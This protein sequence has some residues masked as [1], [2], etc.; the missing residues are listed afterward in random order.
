MNNPFL[1]QPYLLSLDPAHE[2]SVVWLQLDQSSC[3][4]E[5]GDTEELGRSAVCIQY[6]VTGLK[7][8]AN[9]KQGYMETPE[10]NLPLEVYQ[11]IAV[12]RGLHEGERVFYRCVSGDE[13]TRVYDFHAA[14]AEGEGYRFALMSDL[15]GLPHCD[16]TVSRIGREDCDFILYAGDLNWMS[17]QA[18]KWFALDWP[19]Q[20]EDKKRKA[21]FP[22]M[23]QEGSRLMQYC[24]TFFCPGNHEADDLRFGMDK[25]FA[26]NDSCWTTAI[27]MQLMR[28]LYSA[29]EYGRE[30]KRW[31]TVRYGDMQIYSL[32]VVRWALWP[33]NEAPGWKMFNSI[34]P[35]SPQ[36]IWLEAALKGSD[37]RFKWVI[38]H[39]HLLNKGT[40]VQTPLCNPVLDRDGNV[41]YPADYG[42]E[43]LMPLFEKYGVNAVSFGHSHVYERYCV[44][45]IH[46][47]EAA[48]LSICYRE[49]NAPYH[50]TGAIPIV[51]N[52]SFR[53]YAIIERRPGGLF[54]EGHR[55]EGDDGIFDAYQ[56]ADEDGH[57]VI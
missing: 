39:W 49:P 22:C 11:Y 52:N 32:S 41:T 10:E 43:M 36:I 31:Y 15:Q 20:S 17:W 19:C 54:A 45:G 28:P 51:E 8:P 35:E 6:T 25:R 48:Y 57:H 37:A 3:H 47:I 5:Y 2:M 13:A 21:F 4:V 29:R 18:D 50:P 12:I 14:P 7:A 9:L 24:P 23:Q 44:N 1:T 16:E 46:Y 26:D 33:A 56:I 55:A 27:F 40:D 34:A 38:E 42:S 30:G 53:S